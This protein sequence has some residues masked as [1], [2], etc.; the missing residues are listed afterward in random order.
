MKTI[1]SYLIIAAL[2]VLLPGPIR[3]AELSI[4]ARFSQPKVA[5]GNPVQYIVDITAV[6]EDAPP[7]MEPINSLPI[8]NTG[9]LRLHNGRNSRSSQTRIVNG[10]KEFQVTNSSILS[11]TP[12]AVGIYTLPGFQINVDG[13]TLQAPAATL[14]VVERAED[15]APT[16]NE[17]IFLEVETPESLYLGESSVAQL[18]LYLADSINLNGI[19]NFNSRADGFSMNMDPNTYS[20]NQSFQ[21]GRNYKVLTW[22]AKITPLSIG[23]QSID[24]QL[25]VSARIPNQRNAL[26]GRRSPFGGSLFDDF[27]EPA[28]RLPLSANKNIQVL[29]LPSAGKPADFDGAVGQFSIEVFTDRQETRLGEPIMYSVKLS[30]KGNFDRIQA[31]SLKDTPEWKQYSPQS[32]T[33]ASGDAKN[34]SVK[35]FDY[36]MTPTRSGH[37]STPAL[38]FVYFDPLST[39]YVTLQSPSIPIHVKDSSQSIPLVT[40]TT[41][42]PAEK[43]VSEKPLSRALTREEALTTLEYQKA[44][45]GM[46]PTFHPYKSKTFIAIQAGLLLAFTLLAFIIRHHVRLRENPQFVLRRKAEKAS[47]KAL[48]KARS[49]NTTTQCYEASLS[50][51]RNA[52]TARSGKNMSNATFTQ[53]RDSIPHSSKK[54]HAITAL[55][56]L[57]RES[58]ALSFSGQNDATDQKTIREQ[59]EIVLKAL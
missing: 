1:H 10:K 31:P 38:R 6:S 15:A 37:L 53:L 44:N 3:C 18:K 50:A 51:I 25:D 47:K 57:C 24:Y 48:K 45:A 4:H 9:G 36:V 56:A 35:R 26:S 27:F 32:L 41:G 34:T 30:G 23:E 42:D 2:T 43:S 22:T 33:E 20:E 40:E 59:L 7:A 8:R 52:I 21:K 11:V 55:E 29:P 14:Q 19:G 54:E 16:L 13:Q 58:D 39:D 28:Q 49:A 17:L 5:L 46:V 12:P